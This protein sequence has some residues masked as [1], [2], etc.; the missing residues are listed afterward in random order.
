MD[1]IGSNEK[2]SFIIEYM[3]AYEEKI[4]MANKYGLF[5]SA[6]M[7]ELFAIEVCR[8]WFGQDFTNLNKGKSTYPFVDLISGDM[9]LFV[10]VTTAEDVPR[11]IK[12]TLENIRDTKDERF[13]VIN[14]VIFFVL[15][16]DSLEKVQ[17]YNGDKQIG[18]ILF[19]KNDNLITTKDVIN[20]AKS[21]TAFLND[22]YS[23]LKLEFERFNECVEKLNEAIRFSKSVGLKNIIGL[24]NGEYEIDRSSLVKKI[25][26]DNEKYV[27]ILGNAGGGKSALCKKILEDEDVILYARAESFVETIDINDIWKC[28][29]KPVLEYLNGKRIVFLLMHWSL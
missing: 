16:N 5:D 14:K 22:L 2:I 27:T 15:T 7:F 9:Q 23:V 11:K 21:D 3:N 19:T 18:S 26:K 10:Q 24:I 29:V 17:D 6:K 8:L 12:T 1:M 28:D 20:K 25:K 13:S 4:K